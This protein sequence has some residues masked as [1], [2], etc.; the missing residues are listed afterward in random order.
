[1][2]LSQAKT[3]GGIGAIL[4][5]VGGAIPRVGGVLSLF[6][7]V[8]ILLAVKGISEEVNDES[9]F[10]KYLMSF[11]LKIGAFIVLIVVVVAAIGGT[12]L[13][14]GGMEAFERE[15]ESFHEISAIIGGILIGIL[16]AWVVF[17]IGAYYLKESYKLIA[18][19]TG[20]G[21][22]KTTGLLYFI[23][24]ILLIVF[25]LGALLLFVAKVLEIV[26]YFSLPEE[27]PSKEV[28][29]AI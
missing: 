2:T 20:V 25:G 1:M 14:K 12:I 19:H 9:I 17:T 4:S 13:T 8:L 29:V 7:F 15:V 23:G 27:I 26:A 22:F 6:G 28:P 10:K 11:I 5:L 24:A 21:I 18:M 3:Y 16:I